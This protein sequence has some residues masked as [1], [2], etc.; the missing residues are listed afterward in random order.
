MVFFTEKKTMLM[1][2]K[3]WKINHV[4]LYTR[5]K[6]STEYVIHQQQD[7]GNHKD[8]SRIPETTPIVSLHRNDSWLQ[9]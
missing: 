4:A 9:M 2:K 1:I 5:W 6:F 7:T 8:N 3:A